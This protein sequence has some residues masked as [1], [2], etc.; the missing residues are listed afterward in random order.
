[1]AR[2]LGD[3]DEF[4]TDPSADTRQPPPAPEPDTSES[5][6]PLDPE[7]TELMMGPDHSVRLGVAKLVDEK[8]FDHVVMVLIIVS[9]LLLAVE[10]PFVNPEGPM[11]ASLTSANIVFTVLFLLEMSAKI[12]AT[13]FVMRPRS[14]MRSGWNV[15]DFLTI[16]VSVIALAVSD[17]PSL[18]S[19]RSLRAM[20]ALRPL[21]M[22]KRAPGLRKIV[23][24]LLRS[25]PAAMNVMAVCGLFFLIFAIFSVGYFKGDL[26]M[27]TGDVVDNVLHSYADADDPD[28]A[29]L[30]DFLVNPKPWDALTGA[31][32]RG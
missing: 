27:C 4:P 8:M 31:S 15:L 29:P 16:I 20:R 18:K 9:S 12:I 10:S 21:R 22:I 26:R 2:A 30:Y 32:A 5:I 1:M 6:F 23:D 24:V 25:I 19:L 14:Y 17:V 13:G 28:G 11:A 7:P 3:D